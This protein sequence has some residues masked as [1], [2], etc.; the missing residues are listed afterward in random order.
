MINTASVFSSLSSTIFLSQAF[1]PAI[2]HLYIQVKKNRKTAPSP[3]GE[4][5]EFLSGGATFP[6]TNRGTIRQ[7]WRRHH[8][9]ISAYRGLNT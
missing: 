8:Q 9:R 3:F 2:L 1:G 4:S 6:G 7:Q 5:H